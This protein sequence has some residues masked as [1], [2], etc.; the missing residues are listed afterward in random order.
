MALVR[1]SSRPSLSLSLSP[2]KV[3]RF[4]PFTVVEP[5][6]PA[7]SSPRSV[8]SSKSRRKSSVAKP[9]GVDPDD[10][11]GGG[12]GGGGDDEGFG[13]DFDDF[14]EGDEDA[15]FDDFEDGFQE[16]ETPAAPVPTSAP[17]VQPLS[18]VRCSHPTPKRCPAR[19]ADRAHS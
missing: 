13:D 19:N 9:K 16:P 7:L 12:S 18:F 3:L 1:T 15:E 5:I 10:D 4:L 14:E 11:D 8:R 6:S 2:S 17:A